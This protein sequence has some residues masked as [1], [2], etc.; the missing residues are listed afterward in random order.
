LKT[1]IVDEAREKARKI[2]GAA[3]GTQGQNHA[4][5]VPPERKE[6]LAAAVP[7]IPFMSPTQPRFSW[8]GMASQV[9]P[10]PA[11]A[12]ATASPSAVQLTPAI[13]GMI[14]GLATA[15]ARA[16]VIIVGLGIKYLANIEPAKPDPDDVDSI[17]KT[18][19][20]LIRMAV[21][22][23]KLHPGW[24]LAAQNVALIGVMVRDGKK[25]PPKVTAPVEPTPAAA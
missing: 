25:L 9:A 4:P 11:N 22:L 24:V 7:A 8:A 3:A 18:C 12:N 15:A 20:A 19:G 16:N 10:A 23:S 14:D 5:S 2:L 17:E 6:A 21:D 1:T 13:E